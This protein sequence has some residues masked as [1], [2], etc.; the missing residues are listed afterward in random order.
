MICSPI[1]SLESLTLPGNNLDDEGISIIGDSVEKSKTL[2]SLNLSCNSGITSA[3]WQGFTKCLRNPTCALRELN[4]SSCSLGDAKANEIAGA[5]SVNTSVRN[6]K[7]DFNSISDAGAIKIADAMAVNS[8]LNIL[9]MDTNRSITALGW[10]AFFNRL[11][12]STCSLK[13]LHIG[14]NRIDDQGAASLVNL[15]ASMSTL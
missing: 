3:G 9:N 6:L 15:L 11:L 2:K 4:V 7:M 12:G 13:E 1:C 14:C 5:L 10:V 8:S